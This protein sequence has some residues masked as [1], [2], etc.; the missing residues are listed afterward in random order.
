MCLRKLGWLRENV[1]DWKLRLSF[2]RFKPIFEWL[3]PF[4]SSIV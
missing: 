2:N 1:I 4:Y 3:E